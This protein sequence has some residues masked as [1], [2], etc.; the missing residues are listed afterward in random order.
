MIKRMARLYGTVVRDENELFAAWP[1]GTVV[2][3]GDV[4]FLTRKGKLFER[5]GNL[6]DF[7]IAFT[8]LKAP[9]L[10]DFDFIF[11]K[12]ID[13][14]FKAAGQAPHAG[15]MLTHAKAVATIDFGRISSIIIVAYNDEASLANL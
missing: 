5:W 11:G 3:V 12:R 9:N 7:G 13:I 15:S 2:G 8:T 1:I 14:R 6:D 10:T 4:G